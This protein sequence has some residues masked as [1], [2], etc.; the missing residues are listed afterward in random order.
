MSQKCYISTWVQ[1]A[2]VVRLW[3]FEMW[4]SKDRSAQKHFSWCHGSVY[5]KQCCCV[6]VCLQ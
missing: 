2:I 3:D 4:K 5:F 1:L 6:K